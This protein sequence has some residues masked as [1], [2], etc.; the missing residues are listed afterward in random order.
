MSYSKII[1]ISRL[2]SGLHES[3]KNGNWAPTGIPAFVKLA[4]QL[5]KTK[6]LT[7][8]ISCKTEGESEI[9]GNKF[10]H[11]NI[12]QYNIFVIPYLN[13]LHFSKLNSLLNNLITIFYCIYFTIKTK[14][15]LFYFDRSNIKTAAFVKLILRQYV[16]IRI[17]GLYPGQKKLVSNPISRFRRIS[18]YYAYRV[19]YDLAVCTQD[20]SGIEFY[21]DRLLSKKTPSVVLL[22]GVERH[23]FNFYKKNKDYLSLLFV[24]T[25]TE[26][27][28]I[29]DLIDALSL[30]K[31]ANIHFK[32]TIIGK[33]DLEEHIQKT[34]FNRDLVDYV[35]LIGIVEHKKIFS[36]YE[37]AD[38]YISL[39]KLGNLSN[40]VLESMTLGKCVIMLG[41]D[42]TDFT[43]VFTEKFVP[44]DKVNFINRENIVDNLVNVLVHLHENYS[45]VSEYS[46]QMKKFADENFWTWDERIGYEIKL[47]EGILN[48]K[49]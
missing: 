25:L 39:N 16:V 37:E 24:G 29:I 42:P 15:K 3:I 36:Y 1:I 35:K 23:K 31:K 22:N 26:S 40:T 4:E 30:I 14:K 19:K 11:L 7:W 41:K 18:E 9:V 20:G 28:G 33:G 47:L 10:L 21:L 13:I 32:A 12:D 8:L 38:I 17:L 46:S 27:K 48:K 6:E 44:T 45:L 34:I 5:V 2:F 49:N 43:D